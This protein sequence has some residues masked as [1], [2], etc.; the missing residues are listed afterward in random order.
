MPDVPDDDLH[1]MP[2]EPPSAPTR[3]RRPLKFFIVAAVVIG[4]VVSTAYLAFRSRASRSAP[5]ASAAA[6]VEEP[7]PEQR[8]PLGGEPIP[9]TLPSLDESDPFVRTLIAALSSYP[10]QLTAW[11]ATKGLVRN[12]VVVVTNIAD[13]STPAPHLGRLRPSGRFLVIERDGDL[14]VDPRSYDR[15]TMLAAAAASIDPAGSA[16]LYATLKPLL[17]KA[18]RDLGNPDTSFDRTIERAIVRLLNTPVLNDPVR[19]EPQGEGYA[20]EDADVEALTAA[21]KQLL[22]FGSR[23]VLRIQETLR[24]IALAVGIPAQRLPGPSTR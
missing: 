12:F 18:S 20:F 6:S 24:N 5:A 3:S 13:G 8:E 17:E 15:Y 10:S 2:E 1:K 9:V 21:Q 14:Y 19:V 4:L 16:R 7:T 23:N 11:L 22:R